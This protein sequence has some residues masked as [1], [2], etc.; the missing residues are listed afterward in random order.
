MV[1]PR[2]EVAM[3]NGQTEGAMADQNTEE[4][5]KAVEVYLK[6]I[7]NPLRLNG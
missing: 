7:R 2:M 5:S 6:E 3:A 4:D 1:N